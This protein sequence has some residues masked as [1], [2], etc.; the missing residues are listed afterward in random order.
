MRQAKERL[1]Q[2]K[3]RCPCYP[4]RSNYRSVDI[5]LRLLYVR[6]EAVLICCVTSY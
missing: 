3:L 4:S 6:I 5:R 2:T 1:Q